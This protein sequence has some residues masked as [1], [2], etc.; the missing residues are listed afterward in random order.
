[1]M[2]TVKDVPGSPP[3]LPVTAHPPLRLFLLGRAALVMVTSMV[4]VV[5]FSLWVTLVAVS[6][7]TVVAALVLPV[8]VLVRRYADLHRRGAERLL[9]TPIKGR[10]RGPGRRG[11]IARVWVIERD[12]ASW[13]DACWLLLHAVVGCVTAALSFALFAGGVFYLVY[14]FLYWV[15]PHR[16]F[17][18]PFGDAVELHSVAQ[19]LIVMPLAGVCFVLW[20]VLAIPLARVELSLT[21]SL[22]A[23]RQP[24]S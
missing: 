10:Y 12:P 14:P 19:A 7:I 13:R 16:V 24:P 15:T 18:R 23:S 1:M 3:A 21:R 22:L 11:P 4:G 17:G 9:G 8:T 6:P 5:L 20:Y 2:V